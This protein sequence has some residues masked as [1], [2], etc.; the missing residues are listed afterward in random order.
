MKHARRF[1]WLVMLI[2]PLRAAARP[3]RATGSTRLAR[4]FRE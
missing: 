3:V 2:A 1:A 4:L